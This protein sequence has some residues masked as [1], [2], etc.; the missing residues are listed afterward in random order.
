MTN[1]MLILVA[2]VIVSSFVVGSHF[3]R[4]TYEGN[5]SVFEHVDSRDQYSSFISPQCEECN[6]LAKEYQKTECLVKY[7]CITKTNN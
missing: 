6:T 5:T 1:K 2:I 4:D 7:A 3:M